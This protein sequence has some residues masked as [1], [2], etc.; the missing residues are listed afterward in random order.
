MLKDYG[1][2][3][4]IF[5]KYEQVARNCFPADFVNKENI[6]SL[7]KE[8]QIPKENFEYLS[9]F[10]DYADA[11]LM[12]FI[13]LLY[14]V[15]YESEEDFKDKYHSI[16]AWQMPP[17]AEAK[18]PGGVG[19]AVCLL[20]VE[21]LK[22]WVKE[23]NLGEDIIDG[24]YTRYRYFLELNGGNPGVKGMHRLKGFLYAYT[25][26]FFFRLG[27]LAFEV[28]KLEKQ[29]EAYVDEKGNRIY[30][31]SPEGRFDS[32]GALNWKAEPPVYLKKGNVLRAQKFNSMGRLEPQVTEIDLTKYKLFLSKNDYVVSI[33]I[34]EG[35][36][37]DEQSVAHSFD[38]AK[39][40]IGKY[41]PYCKAYVCHTWFIDP[42]LVDEIVKKGGNMEKFADLF[43]KV[44]VIDS[45]NGP[46]FELVFKTAP[47]PLEELVPQNEF[48]QKV[49][50]RA[51]R[52]EKM[53][54]CYGIL[55]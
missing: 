15:Q 13:W 49:L 26:P 24:Y 16:D 18:F 39:K 21:N 23:R 1:I 33:H 29:V 37:L 45:Y 10:L 46:I 4:E 20:A 22:K 54:W 8:A 27:R 42:I 34:P 31:A 28:T 17:E 38:Y 19:A 44:S 5:T 7:A 40:I 50:N 36:R 41:F 47:K 43:D 3:F 11:E 14:Y 48:Q 2:N 9:D 51:L 6:L 55:K 52:G 25:K 53:Y 30:V 12:H 32:D 35:G